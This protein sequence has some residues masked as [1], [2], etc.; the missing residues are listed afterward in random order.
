[1]ALLEAPGAAPIN[2]FLSRSRAMAPGSV[3]LASLAP[4]SPVA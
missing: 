4:L 1:M 3:A 2:V